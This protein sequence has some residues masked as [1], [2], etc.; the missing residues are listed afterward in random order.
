MS[1]FAAGFK[2][3]ITMI[4]NGEYD[5]DKAYKDSK[6]CNV[7][8]SIEFARRLKAEKST[9]TC[10][11][12]NPGL[13]PTTGLFRSINPLFVLIFTFL[14]KN[15]FRVAVSEEEGGKCLAYMIDNPLLN[16]CSGGYFT[17]V[18]GPKGK[19]FGIAVA[20]KEAQD[21]EKGRKLWFLTEKLINSA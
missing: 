13:I 19:E 14:T 10:N 12:M 6:L 15:I 3:P 5:P 16:N 18:P 8:T 11:V 17:A 21:E 2:A 4:D 1:G 9:I 7:M 20:S